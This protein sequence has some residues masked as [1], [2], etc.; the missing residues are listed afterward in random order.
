MS[1]RFYGV[2][3]MGLIL[4]GV[5]V[6]GCEGALGT[7]SAVASVVAGSTVT[8]VAAGCAVAVALRARAAVAAFATGTCLALNITFGLRSQYAG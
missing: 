7:G 4:A 8:A 6:A 2:A 5:L 1:A 3:G